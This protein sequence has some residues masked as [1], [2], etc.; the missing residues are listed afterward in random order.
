MA[1]TFI[2][3]PIEHTETPFLRGILTSSLLESGLD[4]N[5]AYDLASRVRDK[6]ANKTSLTTHQ[7]RDIVIRELVKSKHQEVLQRYKQ[8]DQG[9]FSLKVRNLDGK[10]ENFSVLTHRQSLE[11]TGLSTDSAMLITQ[12]LQKQLKERS[13]S[14]PDVNEIGRLTHE[15][16]Y[17]QFGKEAADRYLVWVDYTR[18]G[19]PLIL[20]LGGTTGSGKS[21]IATEIAHRLGIVRTQSTDMLRE[22]MR[23]MI[24]SR[25]LPTLYT[26]SFSAWRQLP[27]QTDMEA[28][29]Q[30]V[31]MGYNHQAELV[32]VPCEAVI[33]RALTERVS[34]ILEGIHVSPALLERINNPEGAVIVPLMLAVLKPEQLKSQLKGRGSTALERPGSKYLANFDQIWKLQSYLLSEADKSHMEIIPND[35]KGLTTHRVMRAINTVLARQSPPTLEHLFPSH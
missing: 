13:D 7:L 30:L 27:G 3:D 22:V 31:T 28:T 15:L 33:Q 9:I 17:Q 2:I 14:V 4:F 18:S 21:T 19:D 10:V 23:M 29:E 35:D 32:A 16:L 20:L 26:S 8:K 5:M 12:L 34:L 6:L 1:K 25:L 24:P 11:S